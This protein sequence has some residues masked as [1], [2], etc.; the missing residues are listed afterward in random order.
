[1]R[2][3]LAGIASAA[4]HAGAVG[5][6]VLH[7]PPAAS[8]RRAS[9]VE[10]EVVVVKPPPA[11]VLQVPLESLPGGDEDR[12]RASVRRADPFPGA[13]KRPAR[14]VQEPPLVAALPTPEPKAAPVV[15]GW[16]APPIEQ[17]SADDGEAAEG[18]LLLQA[19]G[20][21]GD[22]VGEP[23]PVPSLGRG[24]LRALAQARVNAV[25]RLLGPSAAQR[26][27]F[28]GTAV[29]LVQVNRR[30]YVAVVRLVRSAG[31]RALD[32]ELVPI[33]HLAEPYLPWTGL[34]RLA[35]PVQ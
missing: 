14:R 26:A 9:P 10:F 3:W 2:H 21:A 33:L 19:D 16:Q 15:A 11:P 17:P 28:G 12:P 5:A 35:V 13:P 18:E 27:G 32:R 8:E 25:A 22:G 34:L 24:D 6:L 31:A 23:G 4:V 1:M 7:H 20:P 29:V 30:G